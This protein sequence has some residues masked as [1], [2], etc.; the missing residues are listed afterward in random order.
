MHSVALSLA[1]TNRCNANKEKNV[2][3]YSPSSL[4]SAPH[5]PEMCPSSERGGSNTER[6]ASLT[7]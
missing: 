7:I 3:A 6:S 2:P 1:N 4:V 5:P